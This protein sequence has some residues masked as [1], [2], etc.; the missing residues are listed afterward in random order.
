MSKRK[1]AT[2]LEGEVAKKS[3]KKAPKTLKEKILDLLANQ[4][5]FVGLPKIKSILAKVYDVEESASNNVKINK[6]LKLLS[7]EERDDFGKIG[8]SYHGGEQSPAYLFNEAYLAQEQADKDARALE[9]PKDDMRCP[10]CRDWGKYHDFI[11]VEEESDGAL[12][13]SRETMFQ[14]PSCGGDFKAVKNEYPNGGYDVVYHF[15]PDF[16]KCVDSDGTYL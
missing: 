1:A 4:E 9:G 5:T 16:R 14:C 3:D 8:G 7:E 13:G 11:I 10:N 2:K 6:A 15:G 12:E